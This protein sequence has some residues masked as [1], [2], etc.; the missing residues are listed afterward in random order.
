LPHEAPS[1]R[2]DPAAKPEPAVDQTENKTGHAS[3]PPLAAARLRRSQPAE[4][5]LGA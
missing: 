1:L 3:S 5:Q 4:A 2:L